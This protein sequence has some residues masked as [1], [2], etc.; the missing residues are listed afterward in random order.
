MKKREQQRELYKQLVQEHATALY[1]FCVRR[2]GDVQTSE[3]LVQETFV[4]AWRGIDSLR[5]PGK[6][7]AWLFQILRHRYAR[8]CARQQR[9][10]AARAM[11][12]ASHANPS[13]VI[14][15]MSY[16]PR[17]G[18]E[19][20]ELL[21]KGLD[22]LDERY[23]E[24]FLLVCLVGCTCSEVAALLDIPL[25]TVLSRL[26]RARR[27]LRAHMETHEKE[28]AQAPHQQKGEEG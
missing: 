8:W 28:V 5:E 18:F 6:A 13:N 26:H 15:L 23:K 10:P 1:R 4:E 22:A 12:E 2:C 20:R 17:G 9:E 3:D 27:A 11:P 7:K 25:G 24:P 16:D 21:Q 19:Q 14:P